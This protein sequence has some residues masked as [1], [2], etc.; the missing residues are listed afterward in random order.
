MVVLGGKYRT[1]KSLEV[2]CWWWYET[3]GGGEGPSASCGSI[4][5]AGE[6]FTVEQKAPRDP[7]R[8]L[9]RLDNEEDLESVMITTG[10]RVTNFDR[11]KPTPFRVELSTKQ[12]EES[13]ERIVE[14]P[15]S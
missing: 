8:I 11:L 6:T 10:A 7:D 14:A 5:P 9:C 15:K 4:L 2:T 3:A 1:K 12:I 13:A